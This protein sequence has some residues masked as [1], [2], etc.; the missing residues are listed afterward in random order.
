MLRPLSA[1]VDLNESGEPTPPAAQSIH[2]FHTYTR[3]LSA[4]DDQHML[5]PES[6]TAIDSL[7]PA[8]E[9][10]TTGPPGPPSVEGPRRCTP[11]PATLPV[12][13]PAPQ[14]TSESTGAAVLLLGA[15]SIPPAIEA[16]L[17]LA[18]ASE[19]TLEGSDVTRRWPRRGG[20]SGGLCA[21]WPCCDE[22]GDTGREVALDLPSRCGM[23]V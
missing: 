20:G 5:L 21:A 1:S 15:V 3:A 13:L 7:P 12:S 9:S 22:A 2:V 23:H 4:H 8:S 17:T 16:S 19:R 6:P 10:L 18:T 14:G 11:A